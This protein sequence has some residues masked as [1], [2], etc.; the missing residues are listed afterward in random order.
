MPSGLEWGFEHRSSLTSCPS[1]SHPQDEPLEDWCPV[2]GS[3][4]QTPPSSTSWPTPSSPPFYPQSRWASWGLM[5]SE[6]GFQA[7]ACLRTNDRG[8]LVR[9]SLRLCRTLTTTTNK[10]L[11]IVLLLASVFG[12][13][14]FGNLLKLKS[15]HRK[16][17]SCDW[18]LLTLR[19]TNKPLIFELL[20][21]FHICAS[22]SS[23]MLINITTKSFLTSI[24]VLLFT[25]TKT[26]NITTGYITRRHAHRHRYLGKSFTWKFVITRPKPAYG[27]QGLDWD[28][29]AR[30]QFSQVHFGAKLDSTDLHD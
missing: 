17:H 10:P 4:M 13:F 12:Q 27:R 24:T 14:V 22:K 21:M 9:W 11:I 5:P 29:W 28:R 8:P 1:T 2:S 3:S 15:K 30:I 20:S 6:W 19:T 25:I 18:V 16:F 26:M 7:K 23:T